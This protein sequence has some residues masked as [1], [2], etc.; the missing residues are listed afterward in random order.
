MA[1][2]RS[3]FPEFLSGVDG[4][5]FPAGFDFKFEYEGQ[6]FEVDGRLMRADEFGNFAAGYAFT[7]VASDLGYVGTRLGGVVFAALGRAEHWTD[8]ES[9]PMIDAGYRRARAER[10]G[11]TNHGTHIEPQIEQFSRAASLT[12]TTGCP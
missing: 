1:A 7:K 6:L 10:G 11:W 12:S 9:V 8:R 5:R 2:V 4:R 3:R